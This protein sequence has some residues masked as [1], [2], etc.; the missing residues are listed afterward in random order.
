MPV[1]GLD[2]LAAD[3][4]ALVLLDA[5][6]VGSPSVLAAPAAAPLREQ[7]GLIASYMAGLDLLGSSIEI[8]L[9]DAA[10]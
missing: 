9:G 2:P 8:G 5:G 10:C 4:S 6:P 3:H 7:F 1:A